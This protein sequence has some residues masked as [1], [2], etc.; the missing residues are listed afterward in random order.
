MRWRADPPGFGT[1]NRFGLGMKDIVPSAL[2]RDA[3]TYFCDFPDAF[4]FGSGQINKAARAATGDGDV[5]FGAT[6]VALFGEISWK[7][8]TNAEIFAEKLARCWRS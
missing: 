4:S 6:V 3:S 5:Y 1:D 2:P 8:W 7:R